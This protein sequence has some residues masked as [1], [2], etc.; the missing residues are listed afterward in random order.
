MKPADTTPLPLPKVEPSDRLGALVPAPAPAAL[1]GADLTNVIVLAH[2]RNASG[3]EAPSVSVKDS[4]RPAPAAPWTD[5]VPWTGLIAGALLLHLALVLTFMREPV[6]MASLDLESVSVEIVLGGQTEAGIAQAPSPE[7]SAPST[8]STSTPEQP[9][10]TEQP[11]ETA[12][13]TKPD[14]RPS[15]EP[16]RD[17][18]KPQEAQAAAAEPE[19]APSPE[20]EPAP[21]V[22]EAEQA[23]KETEPEK[24]KPVEEPVAT[25]PPPKQEPVE[26]PREQTKPSPPR[27]AASQSGVGIGSSRATR[28]WASL[29]SAHLARNKR[30]PAEALS[31]GIGG[32]AVVA[33]AI[34]GGGHVASVRLVR[35]SGNASL[36]RESQDLVRRASPFPAP[37]Q[38]KASITVPVNFNVRTGR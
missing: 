32:T 26:K 1:D 22:T 31:R 2:R 36:D 8:P 6:P 11:T 24:T 5:R 29:V 4:D 9:Q 25:Q 3:A 18:P 20:P 10:Q 21:A 28:D 23:T 12:E 13:Q 33:F 14:L 15:I 37:P 34:D 30:Y 17:E 19:P 16:Q 27:V 38:G 35:S 7:Q